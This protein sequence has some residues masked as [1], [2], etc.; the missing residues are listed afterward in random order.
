MYYITDTTYIENCRLSEEDV[1]NNKNSMLHSL[2]IFDENVL[3]GDICQD[4][5]D[6]DWK[7][8]FSREEEEIE[9][10]QRKGVQQTEDVEQQD[11]FNGE[12]DIARDYVPDGPPP[13]MDEVGGPIAASLPP[14]LPSMKNN[15]MAGD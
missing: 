2:N 10:Y 15:P 13:E 11:D 8:L 3:Y 12:M 4:K 1:Q 14:P 7:K 5:V 9:V 6:D